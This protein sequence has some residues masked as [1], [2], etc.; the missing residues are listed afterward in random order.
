MSVDCCLIEYYYVNPLNNF[1]STLIWQDLV[2]IIFHYTYVV[3]GSNVVNE[4]SA[5]IGSRTEQEVS[6]GTGDRPHV[7]EA[8]IARY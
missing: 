6:G 8:S 5:V 4:I 3:I 7:H 2:K 1:L